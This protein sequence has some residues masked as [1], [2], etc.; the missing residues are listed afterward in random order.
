MFWKMHFLIWIKNYLSCSKKSKKIFNIDSLF[1]IIVVISLKILKTL[2]VCLADPKSID[3]EKTAAPN[4]KRINIQY[5]LDTSS[6]SFQSLSD[7]DDN[8]TPFE[9]NV[10]E[11]K[12]SSNPQ[13]FI[14]ANFYYF[15]LSNCPS[16]WILFPLQTFSL[17]TDFRLPIVSTGYRFIIVFACYC[18][19]STIYQ[20]LEKLRTLHNLQNSGDFNG[21]AGA[22]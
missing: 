6:D 18:W 22:I 15:Y 9:V 10:F 21:F 8:F 12:I 4:I 13:I 11:K 5:Y 20:Q 3:D 1:L 16:E 2:F 7:D 19:R 17:T 14:S